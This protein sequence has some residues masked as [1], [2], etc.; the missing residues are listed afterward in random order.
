VAD[1]IRTCLAA[2]Y[3]IDGAEV[4]VTT[5][6]GVAVHPID[7]DGYGDLLQVADRAM[8]RDKLRSSAPPHIAGV[9]SPRKPSP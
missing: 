4:T 6:V 1:S 7:A 3:F 8:Y 2:P 9:S 5:S